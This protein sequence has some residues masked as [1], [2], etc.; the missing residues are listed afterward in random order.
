MRKRARE[1]EEGG[2]GGLEIQIKVI[3]NVP[4]SK[5][6]NYNPRLSIP[7]SH[8]L[9]QGSLCVQHRSIVCL[10]MQTQMHVKENMLST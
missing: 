5:L 9:K 10:I 7:S 8:K 3:L 6:Q 4:A 2:G 1:E